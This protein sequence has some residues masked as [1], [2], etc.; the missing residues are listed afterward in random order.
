[1]SGVFSRPAPPPPPPP[2]PVQPTP[3]VRPSEVVNVGDVDADQKRKL[4]KVR[5]GSGTGARMT[6]SVLG[7]ATTDSKELLGS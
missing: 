6:Q 4:A 3:V 1:M 5:T 2:P 7:S